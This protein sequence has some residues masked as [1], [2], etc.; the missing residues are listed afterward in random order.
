MSY[1]DL[2]DLAMERLDADPATKLLAQ[3]IREAVDAEVAGAMAEKDARIE[4]LEAEA[5]LMRQRYESA[6]YLRDRH[7]GR[8]EAAEAREARLREAL[9]AA[10]VLVTS[11]LQTPR[12]SIGGLENAVMPQLYADNL[13]ALA[14]KIRQALAGQEAKCPKC[15][16][17]G[18]SEE[19]CCAPVDIRGGGEVRVMPDAIK[20][21]L[22]CDER[23]EGPVARG[24]Y[25]V[26][27]GP[28]AYDSEDE[29][30]E[31]YRVEV[32]RGETQKAAMIRRLC[33][34]ERRVREL[35]AERDEAREGGEQ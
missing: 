16:L 21:C 32:E 3:G 35:E 6:C 28:P 29:R 8:A 19:G 18:H 7:K 33:A 23:F 27:P 26:F 24:E 11:C 15:G 34:L 20:P 31:V 2:Y 1:S 30:L 10:G 14:E 17:H 4:A 25:A 9:E 22:F 12:R 13:K 5:T